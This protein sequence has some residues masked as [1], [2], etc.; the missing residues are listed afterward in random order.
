MHTT[1]TH[2]STSIAANGQPIAPGS[3]HAAVFDFGGVFTESPLRAAR[4]AA[5]AAGVSPSG[6]IDLMMG[7]YGLDSDHPWQRVERGETSLDDYRTWVRAE[8]L[9]RLGVE[10]DSVDVMLHLMTAP[11]WQAQADWPSMFDAIIDSGEIGCR[12]PAPDAFGAAI[13]ALGVTDP[14]SALMIDD[15]EVNAEGARASGMRAVLVDA[16]PTDAIKAARS[17]VFGH[18]SGGGWQQRILK[19]LASIGPPW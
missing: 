16:D 3:I 7:D 12:K 1:S 6:L 15:F 14:G 11:V 2:T 4:M 17:A 5:E 10:I 13:D 19:A 18:S 9:R 8:T